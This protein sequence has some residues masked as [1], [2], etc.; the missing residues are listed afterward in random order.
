MIDEKQIILF[1]GTCN[2]CNFWV[3]FVIKRDKKDEFRFAS[4]QSEIGKKIKLQY[5]ITDEIDSVVLI[6][7]NRAYIRS[8][9]ALEIT[10]NL[11][12]L[13]FLLY[14][15]KIIPSVIRNVV[16]DF[17]A[18]SRYKWF[19]KSDCELPQKLEDKSRFL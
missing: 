19:G 3:N 10:K 15:F 4:L 1:D 16:Y 12:G 13:W 11:K 6:K 17:V 5:Q 8:N 9:A 7:N 2:F 18:R 14:S